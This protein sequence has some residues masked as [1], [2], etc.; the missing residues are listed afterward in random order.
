MVSNPL[1]RSL[2]CHQTMTPLVP[3][4]RTHTTINYFLSSQTETEI[5]QVLTALS[6]WKMYEAGELSTIMTFCKSLPSLFKSFT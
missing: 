5:V 1:I 3:R 2:T 6:G 4:S